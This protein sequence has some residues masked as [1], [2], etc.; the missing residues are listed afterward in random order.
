MTKAASD[1]DSNPPPISIQ[2]RPIIPVKTAS[3]MRRNFGHSC[4]SSFQE[5]DIG[6]SINF[7]NRVG[8]RVAYANPIFCILYALMFL[9]NSLFVLKRCRNKNIRPEEKSHTEDGTGTAET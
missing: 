2:S 5:A 6:N 8:S 9:K 3:V 7:Y 4:R 1:S